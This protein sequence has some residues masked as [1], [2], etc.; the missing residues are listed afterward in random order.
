MQKRTRPLLFR[1]TSRAA[2][3]SALCQAPAAALYAVGCCRSFPDSDIVLILRLGAVAS[4]VSLAFSAFCA[5]QALAFGIRARDPS[6]ARAL[7][8]LVPSS[9][10]S[11]AALLFSCAALYLS[12]RL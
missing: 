1:L 11:L 10:A 12:E 9:A 7:A 8:F 4:A 3:V 2:L 6:F 5:A